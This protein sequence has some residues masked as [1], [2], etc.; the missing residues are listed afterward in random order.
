[1]YTSFSAATLLSL[2]LLSLAITITS[3]AQNAK[4]DITQSNTITWTSV[5]TDPQTINIEIVNFSKFPTY[6]KTIATNVK[7]SANSFVNPANN[8]DGQTGTGFQIN[9]SGT[10][11]GNTGILAQSQ[12][13]TFVNGGGSSSS[14]SSTSS[15][16][17]TLTSPTTAPYPIPSGSGNGTATGTGSMPGSTGGS[18]TGAGG[19][20][21][22]QFPGA[23]SNV[24]RSLGGVLGVAVAAVGVAAMLA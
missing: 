1:M 24:Q 4:W 3:P 6:N 16:S 2:P 11:D 5:S 20:S 9:F 19:S 15:G 7:T 21:P 23:A 10:Q 12:Q 14:S 18:T 8:V 13:V 22:S 17:T